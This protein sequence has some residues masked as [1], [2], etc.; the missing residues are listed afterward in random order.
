MIEIEE[1]TSTKY[2]RL[3]FKKGRWEKEDSD[4]AR[5]DGEDL[6]NEVDNENE[7]DDL[8]SD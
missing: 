8:P 7:V 4:R 6:E 2:P 3:S 1:A 5:N